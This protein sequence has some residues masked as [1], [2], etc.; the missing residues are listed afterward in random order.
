M[1][2]PYDHCPRCGG[3]LPEGPTWP[4]R[5]PS[6]GRE[7][8]LSPAPVGVTLQPVD[9]GLLIIRRG[10]PPQRGEWALPGGFI[11]AYEGWEQGC[12]RE[13]WE[14]TGVRV[15]PDAL[16]LF[17]V[18]NAPEDNMI[19]IFALAPVMSAADLP[20][21]EVSAECTARAV[22]HGPE[23]LAFALHTL[24]ARR[25]FDRRSTK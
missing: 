2:R 19:V 11:D 18:E 3:R 8:Y 5:C 13:L 7:S 4:K 17:S 20:P 12:A 1:H 23:A 14:E 24:A 15:A 16:T 10:I 6:C 25:F 9:D 22:L 21:F